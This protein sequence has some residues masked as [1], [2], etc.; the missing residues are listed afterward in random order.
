MGSLPL[1]AKFGI[2]VFDDSVV[3]VNLMIGKTMFTVP[4][5][6]I[7]GAD[8]QLDY[9]DIKDRI[10]SVHSKKLEV[11]LAQDVA[12]RLSQNV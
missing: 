9:H 11:L 8:E 3:V 4:H 7:M 1:T 2:I 12:P 10:V 5:S 6:T